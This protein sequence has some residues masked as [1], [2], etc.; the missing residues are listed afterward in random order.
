MLGL[1]P[2][3]TYE[4]K[5]QART[6][7]G[8]SEETNAISILAGEVPEQPLTPTTTLSSS[9]I[10]IDWSAPDARG[11]VII[12]YRVL[13]ETSVAS[14]FLREMT[15]CDGDDATIISQT[16]CTIPISQLRSTPF[17]LPWGTDVSA[18]IVA[19]NAY[20][21]SQESEV[22]SGAV[23]V[24]YPSPPINLSENVETRGAT[25]IGLTWSAGSNGGSPILEYMIYMR[26]GSG[27]WSEHVTG[28]E[29]DEYII[30]GLT[31]GTTYQFKLLSRNAYGTSQSYSTSVSILCATVPDPPHSAQTQIQHPNQVVVSWEAP[32]SNNGSPITAYKI[33]FRKHNEHD[34]FVEEPVLCNGA[35]TT[36]FGSRS[37]TE[38][39]EKLM[40]API[41]LVVGDYVHVEVTAI[42]FFGESQRSAVGMGAFVQAVP[43][44][45]TNLESNTAITS[46]GVIGL[47]WT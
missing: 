40:S 30:T 33:Y 16:S 26:V 24:T 19:Y 9:D 46:A 20:G 45:P 47:Q 27:E 7:Y 32:L 34:E 22:G 36:V 1:T 11:S 44:A 42:N 2:G 35:S 38:T 31:T 28:V 8:L 5:L 25:Q 13:I 14:T 3:T 43:D 15:Y 12:G 29:I 41:N 10:R 18:K 39:F 17:N 21:D 37:C 23:I 4:F 6:S